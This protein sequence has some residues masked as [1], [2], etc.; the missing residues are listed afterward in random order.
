MVIRWILSSLEPLC[1]AHV[2]KFLRWILENIEL[3]WSSKGQGIVYQY[4]KM[5]YQFLLFMSM[6][7]PPCLKAC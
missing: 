2:V 6:Y 7:L 4:A 1:L 5:V 3:S